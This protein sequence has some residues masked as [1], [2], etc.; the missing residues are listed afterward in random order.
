[1]KVKTLY[2]LPSRW[3]LEHEVGTAKIWN[4]DWV[5]SCGS[6]LSLTYNSS[7]VV[8][9]SRKNSGHLIILF[10]S[11]SPIWLMQCFDN[12]NYPLDSLT[13][14]GS[15]RAE[16]M[17]IDFHSIICS[18]SNSL[19]PKIVDCLKIFWFCHTY[20]GID[21]SIE[22]YSWCVTNYSMSLIRKKLLIGF[23]KI[24]PKG[25]THRYKQG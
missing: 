20:F 23:R 9:W 6:R 1:M 3:V 5:I 21:N 19:E 25:S 12:D 2:F 8:I 7:Y 14:D 18:T 15:N 10:I 11:L 22:M 13:G 16:E 4:G 24:E 17:Y